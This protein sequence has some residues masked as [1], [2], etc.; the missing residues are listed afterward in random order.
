MK[1]FTSVD[2]AFKWWLDNI[3]KSLPAEEK[4]GRLT[5]AWRDYTHKLGISEKRM[6]DILSEYGDVEVKTEVT[7]T[8]K[9]R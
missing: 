8:P 4:K 5:T 6:K 7:F 9:T 3:Y 1:K 2:E